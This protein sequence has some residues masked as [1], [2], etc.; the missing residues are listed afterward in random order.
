M[1]NQK[2]L[3][4]S[5]DLFKALAHPIRIEILNFISSKGKT[6]VQSIYN[7]LDLPQSV[8]SQQLKILKDAK[9]V[10]SKTASKE[11][12]YSINFSVFQLVQNVLEK[13]L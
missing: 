4:F 5:F 10:V 6:N 8:T 2:K 1:F 9:L 7:A 11:R 12:I 13:K 3:D